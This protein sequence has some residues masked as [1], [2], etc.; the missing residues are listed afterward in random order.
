MGYD[1]EPFIEMTLRINDYLRQMFY[2]MGIDLVDF[3]IEYG[4]DAHGDLYL[5]DEISPDSMRLWKIGSDE[6]FDKDLF[7]KMKVILFLPIVRSLT[8][9]N[10]LL[11]NEKI[12]TS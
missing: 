2:I 5:A 7:R 8:D 12:I 9:Y 3:K 1:P 10:P 4:Y 6:R 11:F